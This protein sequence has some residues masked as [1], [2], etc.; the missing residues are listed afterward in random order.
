MAK[1][2]ARVRQITTYVLEVEADSYGDAQDAADGAAQHDPPQGSEVT[3]EVDVRRQLG[4]PW[5][6]RICWYDLHGPGDVVVAERAFGNLFTK[7]ECELLKTRLT[8]LGLEVVEWWNGVN[9]NSVSFR[10]TGRAGAAVFT[11]DELAMLK[12]PR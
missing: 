10:C 5:L 3:F 8:Q 2:Q 7:E 6:P 12:A 1:W 9:C 11:P 4:E